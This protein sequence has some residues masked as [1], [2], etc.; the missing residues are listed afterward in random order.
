MKIE[1]VYFVSFVCDVGYNSAEYVTDKKITKFEEIQNIC[2]ELIEEGFEN[3][4]ILNYQFLTMRSE[5][6]E[7]K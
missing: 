3:V 4:Q 1:Y 7:F 5:F 2:K 6:D